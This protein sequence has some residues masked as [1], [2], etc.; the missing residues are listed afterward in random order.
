MLDR[1]ARTVEDIHPSR[2]PGAGRRRGGDGSVAEGCGQV[3]L[4]RP[5][6]APRVPGVLEVVVHAPPEDVQAP[7]TPGA[8]RRVGL[9]R[10]VV[11]RGSESLLERPVLAP[12][13]PDV[14]EV[15]V[16]AAVE[17]VQAPLRPRA[18]RGPALQRAQ[19]EVRGQVL[20]PRPAALVGVPRVLEA[21]RRC[22]R[23]ACPFRGSSSACRWH[24]RNRSP[25]GRRRTTATCASTTRAR[26]SPSRRRARPR[27]GARARPIRAPGPRRR[28]RAGGRWPYRRCGRRERRGGRRRSVPAVRRSRR[29]RCA[30][31]EPWWIRSSCRLPSGGWPG[32]ASAV[33][34]Y[35]GHADA[36]AGFIAA[37][38]HHPQQGSGCGSRTPAARRSR[39]RPLADVPLHPAEHR[40]GRARPVAPWAGRT[41]G[42]GAR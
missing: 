15:V 36:Y 2:L 19:P 4:E 29:T 25:P 13:I 42:A 40:R 9:Q 20:F 32:A 1:A 17:D 8:G 28:P 12:R 11:E 6:V 41:G 30:A 37:A 33:T 31:R 21:A 23:P 38:T 7:L 16:R 34:A 14:L 10:A 26:A 39:R 22:D 27:T 24:R 3:L 35:V 18:G 5:I